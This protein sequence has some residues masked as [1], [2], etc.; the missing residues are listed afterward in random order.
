MARAFVHIWVEI[1]IASGWAID[2]TIVVSARGKRS[3]YL[4]PV[5][6]RYTVRI[7]VMGILI[8]HYPFG[9]LWLLFVLH[10]QQL[11]R[12]APCSEL[13][14]Q[15]WGQKNEVLCVDSPDYGYITSDCSFDI[16]PVKVA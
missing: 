8:K 11:P 10:P 14:G 1:K 2:L 7:G 4:V 15:W 13:M 6:S 9:P 12:L 5:E 3:S 16:W